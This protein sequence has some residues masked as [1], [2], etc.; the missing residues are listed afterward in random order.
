MNALSD[1]RK[2]IA[3]RN[4]DREQKPTVP[5]VNFCHETS[6]KLPNHFLIVISTLAGQND[7][8]E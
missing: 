3:A 8:G 6:L 4:R 5:T 1:C 7:F 2:R